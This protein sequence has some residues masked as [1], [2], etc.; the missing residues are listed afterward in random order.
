[1]SLRRIKG[2]LS[3][4]GCS[5][6]C[7]LVSWHMLS[8]VKT[9]L[10]GFGTANNI[11]RLHFTLLPQGR[12]ELLS[13]LNAL[14]DTD[15]S[16]VVS[17][18]MVSLDHTLP[19]RIGCLYSRNILSFT[20]FP[21]AQHPGAPCGWDSLP[22]DSWCLH[23]RQIV[24]AGAVKSF[25][26]VFAMTHDIFNGRNMPQRVNFNAKTEEEFRSNLRL[27]Q[28]A[29]KSGDFKKVLQTSWLRGVLIW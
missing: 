15:Y 24:F 2:V 28:R 17:L 11:K 12:V 3:K 19:T 1:M 25:V 23:G 16:K 21:P 29:L 14:V 9:A 6:C 13:W 8:I 10:G 7:I 20:Y 27:V 26:C 5:F 22:P 4:V 18:C